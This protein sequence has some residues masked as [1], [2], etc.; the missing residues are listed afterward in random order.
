MRLSTRP[1]FLRRASFPARQAES[2][3]RH[4]NEC[5]FLP[6]GCVVAPARHRQR[7]T[8]SDIGACEGACPCLG[9]ADASILPVHRALPRY[10]DEG[11]DGGARAGATTRS[12]IMTKVQKKREDHSRARG[13]QSSGA[14]VGETEA[15][16]MDSST[17]YTCNPLHYPR[18]VSS[19][20]ERSLIP[21]T[22][23]GTER[24]HSRDANL[25]H[26]SYARPLP[27]HLR[28]RHIPVFRNG[29]RTPFVRAVFSSLTGEGQP[30]HVTA[31]GLLV[32]SV[33][34]YWLRNAP[35]AVDERLTATRKSRERRRQRIT[36]VEHG[37]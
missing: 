33:S 19:S 32:R 15:R 2:E 23:S 24:F 9:E 37:V 12:V 16:A 11:A 7:A 21:R 4:G 3:K 34:L 36:M 31:A 6:R 20:S 28:S 22:S 25:A 14:G 13:W 17:F 27:R 10:H 18:E 5:Q 26:P 30:R 29:S 8:E 35:V 1:A